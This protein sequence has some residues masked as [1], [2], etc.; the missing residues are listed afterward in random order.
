[1]GN[2]GEVE[3]VRMGPEGSLR[4]C[5]QSEGRVT[6]RKRSTV[7][8]QEEMLAALVEQPNAEAKGVCT[9]S[10]WLAGKGSQASC[11]HA[12]STAIFKLL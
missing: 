6:K 9:T 7:H 12:P 3:R 8:H 4:V 1:M 5:D 2:K 11:K 10:G